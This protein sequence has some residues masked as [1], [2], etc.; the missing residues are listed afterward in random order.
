VSLGFAP[1]GDVHGIVNGR[2]SARFPWFEP[3]ARPA[4]LDASEQA[5]ALEAAALVGGGDL[6]R[7]WP[8][9]GGLFL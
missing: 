5:A 7:P 6:L 3:V 9:S 2:P 1:A 8:P 4:A